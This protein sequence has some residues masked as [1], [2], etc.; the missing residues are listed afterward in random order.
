MMISR[1]TTI[2]RRNYLKSVGVSLGFVGLAGCAGG[3][4]NGENGT[5]IAIVSSPAGFDDN[6][7][8][9]NALLG[10]QEADEE[11]GIEINTVEETEVANYESVQSNLADEGTNDLI[12]LIASEHQSALEQNA[13]NHP[14]QNWMLINE[15]VD[16][17]NVS[18]WI[19]ANHEM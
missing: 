17:P 6:A 2:D 13:A 10:L 12:V 18:G 15:H 3:D 8:N 19:E 4:D 9:D 7:F 5:Q 14:D 1:M 16:E 11:F